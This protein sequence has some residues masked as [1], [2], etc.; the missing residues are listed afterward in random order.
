MPGRPISLPEVQ[1]VMAVAETATRVLESMARSYDSA[2]CQRAKGKSRRLSR[3]A[4]SGAA[5]APP[6]PLTNCLRALARFPA[7]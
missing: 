7:L 5:A 4:S 2:A 1:Q 3:G 6:K